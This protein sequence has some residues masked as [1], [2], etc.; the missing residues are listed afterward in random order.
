MQIWTIGHSIRSIEEFIAASQ[1]YK[2]GLVADVCRFPGSRRNP[3]FGREALRHSLG[4]RGIEYGHFPELGGRRRPRPD[5]QN[6]GWR[7]LAFMVT[8][9]TWKLANF[10]PALNV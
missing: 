2:I 9:T 10:T 7:S 6:T 3:Q 5:S 1:W 4:D 8:L